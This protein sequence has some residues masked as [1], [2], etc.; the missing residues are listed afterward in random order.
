MRI[1]GWLT[2]PVAA[3]T[4]AVAVGCGSVETRSSEAPAQD[5]STSVS[6]KLGSTDT[7]DAVPTDMGEASDPVPAAKEMS[8]FSRPRTEAD[9]LPGGLDLPFRLECTEWHL[10][11][12]WCLGDPIPEESRLLLSGLGVT[13]L[14]LYAWPTTKGGVCL[15]FVGEGGGSCI[16]DFADGKTR[17]QYMGIDPD[18]TGSGYPSTFIGL[19]PDDV[20]AAQ[21]QVDG[22]AQAAIVESNALFYELPD[23]SCTNWAFESLTVTYRDGSSNMVPIRWHAG[24]GNADKP[25]PT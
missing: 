18:H 14:S 16:R 11:H 13:N 10:A 12:G 25:C 4:I 19:V 15:A 2:F 24:P 22:V 8:V 21:I 20:V 1:G 6:P 7:T 9:V 23:G 17:V 3:I 5:P